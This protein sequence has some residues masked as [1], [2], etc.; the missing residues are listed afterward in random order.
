MNVFLCLPIEF[1]QSIPNYKNTHYTSTYEN[2]TTFSNSKKYLR[3]STINTI[4]INLASNSCLV[5]VS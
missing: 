5:Y 4:Y 3:G 2:H 1:T